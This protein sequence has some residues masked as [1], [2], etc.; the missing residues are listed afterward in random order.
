MAEAGI[1]AGPGGGAE[2]EL[3][4][5]VGPVSWLEEFIG[6]LTGEEPKPGTSHGGPRTEIDIEAG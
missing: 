5:G 1:G 2:I 4:G 3:T 6:E